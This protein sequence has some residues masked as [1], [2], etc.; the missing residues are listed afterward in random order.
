ML[1]L[2]IVSKSLVSEI[3]WLTFRKMVSI[4]IATIGGGRYWLASAPEDNTQNHPGMPQETPI[5]RV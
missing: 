2:P 4:L 5:D 3:L 1:I